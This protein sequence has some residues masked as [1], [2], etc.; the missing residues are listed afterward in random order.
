MFK[1][2][3]RLPSAVFDN[4]LESRSPSLVTFLRFA[5]MDEKQRAD[6]FLTVEKVMSLREIA[7]ALG[8]YQLSKEQAANGED[9]GIF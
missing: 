1:R 9:E 5:F 3:T 2:K 7:W 6:I 8:A 4:I